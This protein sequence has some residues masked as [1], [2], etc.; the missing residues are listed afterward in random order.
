VNLYG[1]ATVTDEAKVPELVHKLAYA[2]AGCAD[3]IRQGFLTEFP[4]DWLWLAFLAEIREEK[5][6]A[7]KSLLAR[8]EQL[9]DQVLFN[10][11]VAGQQ[12]WRLADIVALSMRQRPKPE[13]SA[14]SVYCRPLSTR[15]QFRLLQRVE[16]QY[17]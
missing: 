5:E 13:W 1:A 15:W 10:P 17:K 8:I 16:P 6:E 11:T 9:I 3:H 14:C 12:A 4:Y 7:H 2:R